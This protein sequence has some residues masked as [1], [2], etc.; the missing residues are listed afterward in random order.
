MSFEY[1]R[2]AGHDFERQLYRFVV[3]D[4]RAEHTCGVSFLAMDEQE[5]QRQITPRDRPSQFARQ[6]RRIVEAASRKFHAGR[7]E[8]CDTV[9]TVFVLRADLAAVP[10][11]LELVSGG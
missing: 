8:H 7:V 5:R 1:V 9:L 10:Q 4:G 3:T 6:R 2:D 11:E